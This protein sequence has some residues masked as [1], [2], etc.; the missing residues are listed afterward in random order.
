MALRRDREG[1]EYR[2]VLGSVRR[3]ADRLRKVVESLLFLARSD[4]DAGLPGREAVDLGA[5]L[6]EHVRAAWAGHPRAGDIRV[7]ATPARADV[8][9]VLLGELVDVLVDNACKYSPPGTAVTVRAGRRGAGV[10]V[11]VEDAGVGL[12]GADAARVFE[13]FYRSEGARR[14]GVEGSGLGLAIA[15]RI[16]AAHGGTLGV[17]SAPG[18]GSRFT[19]RLPAGR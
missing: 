12:S 4:A 8:H 16:A 19:L 14:R 13:P 1:A 9:P 17:E 11:S 3:Q 15:G 5:W 6:P 2:R 7:E 18:R 10:E